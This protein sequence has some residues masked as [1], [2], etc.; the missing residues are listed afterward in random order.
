MHLNRFARQMDHIGRDAAMLDSK[1]HDRTGVLGRAD[2][3]G[4]QERLLDMIDARDIG[5]VLRTANVQHLAIGLKDVIVHT[6][7]RGDELK[8]KLSL[9]PLLD[10]LHMQQTQEANTETK[11]KRHGSLRL[12]DKRGIVNVQFLERV[13]KILVI[14]VVDREDAGVDHRFGLAVTRQGSVARAVS[15]R[16]GIAHMNSLGVL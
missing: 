10:N 12:P 5:K 13:A 16:Q 6:G 11:A 2:D 1:L 3:L 4:V 8:S 9:E 14:F 7:A 15:S